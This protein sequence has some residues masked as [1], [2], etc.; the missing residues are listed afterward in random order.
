[1]QWRSGACTLPSFIACSCFWWDEAHSHLC[2]TDDVQDEQHILFHCA[3]PHVISLRRKYASLFPPTGAHD[4]VFTFLSQN[5]NK[6]YHCQKASRYKRFWASETRFWTLALC[7]LTTADKRALLSRK[8]A[9]LSQK[10]DWDARFWVRNWP[11][12]PVSGYD[13]FQAHEHD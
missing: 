13:V 9:F 11:V 5:N 10:H 4:L 12:N 8:R 2:D 7:T 1:M 6:L 3:N